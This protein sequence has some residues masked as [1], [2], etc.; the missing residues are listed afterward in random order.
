MQLT[1]ISE[2]R[3]RFRATTITGP[4]TSRAYGH[5]APLRQ[6][7]PDGAGTAGL[8][9]H[10]QTTHARAQT[11]RE[12]CIHVRITTPRLRSSHHDRSRTVQLSRAQPLR[13]GSSYGAAAA[14][15][16]GDG[17]DA[18][19]AVARLARAAAATFCAWARR[20][21]RRRCSVSWAAASCGV[22]GAPSTNYL[23]CPE[24]GSRQGG[25]C[26]SPRVPCG[27]SGL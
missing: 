11:A 5:T 21:C 7:W 18:S 10:L 13:V 2:R 15:A 19:Q 25:Q 12:P 1:R 8:Q 22:C 27:I 9:G 3:A 24:S 14:G 23:L 26:E 6:M 17:L 16:R 4:D 20:S